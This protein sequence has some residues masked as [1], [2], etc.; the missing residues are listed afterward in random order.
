MVRRKVMTDI[1]K[2]VGIVSHGTPKKPTI[3]PTDKAFYLCPP[4]VTRQ[5]DQDGWT[6]GMRQIQ[7][8]D[9][10]LKDG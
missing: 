1:M 3:P 8:F 6:P 4:R 10:G 2:D 5:T 9:E 7:G